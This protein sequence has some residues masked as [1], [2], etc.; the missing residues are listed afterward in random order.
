M[1]K[2]LSV[3]FA[4]VATL[5]GET[6]SNSNAINARL[7]LAGGTMTGTLNMGSNSI[8]SANSVACV[9]VRSAGDFIVEGSNSNGGRLTN[10]LG[11]T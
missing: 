5:Q 6:A 9:S 10:D 8:V 3:L 4:D 11:Y 2:D 1:E 7:P